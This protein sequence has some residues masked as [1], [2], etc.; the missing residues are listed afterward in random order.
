MLSCFANKTIIINQ[1][2]S[3]TR[4]SSQQE[5]NVCIMCR[6][7]RNQEEKRCKSKH[8]EAMEAIIGSRRRTSLQQD[9]HP[10]DCNKNKTIVLAWNPCLYHVVKLGAK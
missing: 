10:S 1:I 6:T 5:I 2:A 8:K 3:E 4:R 9:D 7:V